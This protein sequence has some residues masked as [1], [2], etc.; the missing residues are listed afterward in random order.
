MAF[1]ITQSV[2]AL[3]VVLVSWLTQDRRSS[4]TNAVEV[5][6]HVGDMQDDPTGANARLTR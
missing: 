3:A 6:V 1:G 2:F 5:R 4:G